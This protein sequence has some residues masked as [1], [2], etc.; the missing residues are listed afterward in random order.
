MSNEQNKPRL[1]A[2][3]VT[4]RCRYACRHCRANAYPE[5]SEEELTTEQCKRILSSVA[6]F[7]SA[8][9]ETTSLSLRKQG[10]TLILTGGE[11]MERDDI[12]ELICYGRELGLRM[13]MATCGY[14][15]DDESIA[16]LK[17]AGIL[18]LSF[19]LDGAGA[20]T[21]DKF[22]GAKGAFDAV[23]NAAQSA[24]Q[25]GVH[26]QINTTLSKINVGEVVGIAELAKRLGAYCFNPFIFVPTGRGK[27]IEDAM[28]EPV[29]YEALLG[30]LLRIK[31]K[32]EIE[33]R[34]TC[35]PQFSRVCQQ[36]KERHLVERTNGCMGGRGF[37]FIS[38][39]GDVQTC[40]FLDISAGNLVE[41]GFDFGRIW[42]G[43]EFLEEVRNLSGYK[44]KCGSCEYVGV[45][46]GCRARAF[47]V[48]GDY[49]G[50]DPI[51]DYKSGSE[52]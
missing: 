17:K 6:K 44:D 37:G 29:Q 27:E 48:S 47:A 36:V 13:V 16:K 50:A 22:R 52:S 26:F 32:G 7:V 51:C 15:I 33:L 9:A 4:R 20:E 40:G 1:I 30:E 10:C 35:A 3:E 11:P 41:N 31:L 24:K 39:R 46:G 42:V 38:R 12:Y 14:L 23:V 19:S 18:A 5:A 45:C 25:A 8:S 21:H 43:S 2:F 49:L 34:V 28:L